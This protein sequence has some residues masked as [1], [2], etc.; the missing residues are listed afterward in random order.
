M[1]ATLYTE[2]LGKTFLPFLTTVY[3]ESHRFMADND[4]KHASNEVIDFLSEM[5]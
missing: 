3:P 1:D 4:P 5:K 2:V